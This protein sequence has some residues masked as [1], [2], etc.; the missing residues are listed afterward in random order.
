MLPR[1]QPAPGPGSELS[2][3]LHANAQVP[4]MVSGEGGSIDPVA[5]PRDPVRE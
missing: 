1:S 5:A 2:P 3:A 4:I